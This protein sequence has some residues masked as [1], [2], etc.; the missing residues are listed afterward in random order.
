MSKYN[1]LNVKLT[2]SR[3][4][5][6]KYGMKNGTEITLNHLSDLIGNFNDETIFLHKLLLTD[7]QVSILRKAFA[8]GSSTNIKFK[9]NS[10][11]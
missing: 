8:N 3:L 6:L 11:V 9:K 1:T 10:V 5:K 7:T 2:N 4:N